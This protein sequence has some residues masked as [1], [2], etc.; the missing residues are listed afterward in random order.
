[1][2][3][4]IF[5]WMMVALLG[6]APSVLAKL[7]VVATLPDFGAI[8]SAVGGDQVQVTTLA[9]GTEDPHFVDARPSFIRVL[10]KADVLIEGGA[11]LEIGWLPPLVNN[12]R[13]PKILGNEPGHVQLAKAV[14]L[15]DVPTG[16]I[17]RSMGDVHPAG[18]PHFNLDPANGPAM[19]AAIA[20]A[21]ARLDAAH[22]ATYRRNAEQFSQ[23]LNVKLAEWIKALEPYR[24]TKVVTYHKTYDYFLERFG[25]GLVGLIEPR[26][27]LEPSPTHINALI[28]KIKSAGVRLILCEPNRPHKTPDH[29]AEATGARVVALPALVGGV[30]SATDYPGLFDYNVRRLTE[31]L[32]PRQNP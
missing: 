6:W 16:P 11:E 7:N 18:N 32:R 27:G 10:N 15:I 1:M 17:D 26:P 29:L 23:R 12:A 4:G 28:P 13:N 31:A 19:A 9:R 21:L 2:K 25:F 14:R 5:G 22:A 8:A 3:T 24:G 20:E 30:E